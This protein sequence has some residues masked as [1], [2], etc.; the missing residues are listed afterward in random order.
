[1]LRIGIAHVLPAL[2]LVCSSCSLLFEIGQK[3]CASDADCQVRGLANGVCVA[4]LCQP[5]EASS[6][7]GGVAATPAASSG[8]SVVGSAGSGAT[9]PTGSPAPPN[10][11]AGRTPAAIGGTGGTA[12]M[13]GSSGSSGR[14]SAISSGASAGSSGAAGCAGMSCGECSADP[15]CEAKGIADGKCVDGRCFAPTPECSADSEC[16]TRGPEWVGGRCAGTQCR[17]NPKWRCEPPPPYSETQPLALTLPVIDSFSLAKLP[18]VH[19]VACNKLDYMCLMPVADA[20]TDKDGNLKISVPANFNG[21]FQQTERTDYAPALYFTPQAMP[22]D[23]MLPNFPL[24]ASGPAIDALATTLGAKIDPKRGQMILIIHDCFVTPLPGVTFSSPQ[25]DML[26]TPFYVRASIPSATA[27]E[28]P[29]DGDGGYLNMPAGTV[30]IIAKEVKMGIDLATA[31]VLVRPGFMTVA[32]IRP[33][34]RK[35]L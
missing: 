13:A 10:G 2:V 34:S 32:Y 25:A 19:I 27:T 7:T 14:S 16:V 31:S 1:M 9:S 8:G 6:P 30:E 23:G 20:T 35:E 15:E 22:E 33:K 4:N 24:I 18:N 28:T 12:S 3:Q 17:P 21:Y 5:Y 29:A 26:T 11:S